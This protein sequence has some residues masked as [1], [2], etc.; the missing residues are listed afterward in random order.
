MFRGVP[1]FLVHAILQHHFS[2]DGSE[3]GKTSLNISQKSWELGC[4]NPSKQL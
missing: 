1:V 4:Y 2:F 3:A